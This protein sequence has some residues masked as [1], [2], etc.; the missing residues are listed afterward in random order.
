[1]ARRKRK[2]SAS[3]RRKR[4]RQN[5]PRAAAP[6]Q[7]ARRRRNAYPVAFNPRRRG[8][9]RNPPVSAQGILNVVVQGV[10]DA[11]IVTLGEA[12][13]NILAAQIPAFMKETKTAADGTPVTV[14]TQAGAALRRVAAAA[15]VAIGAQMLF[16]GKRDLQRFAVAGALSAPVKNV[17]RPLLPTTGIFAGALSSGGRNVR[18]AAYPASLSGYPGAAGTAARML[19]SGMRGYPSGRRNGRVGNGNTTGGGGYRW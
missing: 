16:A 2:R 18:F 14:E 4:R 10:T 17:I 7:R 11:A 1:M 13:A 15:G 19:G 12:S 8:R 3:S 9:R 6:R 5:P